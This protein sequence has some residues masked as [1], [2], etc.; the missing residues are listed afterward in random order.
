MNTEPDYEHS[1]GS[2]FSDEELESI[3]KGSHLQD[4]GISGSSST[5]MLMLDIKRTEEQI[6]LLAAS[7]RDFNARVKQL[8]DRNRRLTRLT[9]QALRECRALTQPS[10]DPLSEEAL[11]F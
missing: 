7:L 10:T 8:H 11:G 6:E 4:S 5:E 2:A 3:A 1:F 9:I